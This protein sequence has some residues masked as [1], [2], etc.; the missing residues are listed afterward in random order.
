MEDLISL[1]KSLKP[2]FTEEQIDY[3]LWE[4]TSFPF[5][6]T[7]HIKREIINILAPKQ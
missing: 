3:L 1:I 6:T 2:D 5:G 7:E 4:R